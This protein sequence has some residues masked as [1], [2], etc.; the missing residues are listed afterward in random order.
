MS[1]AGVKRFSGF[2]MHE[3]ILAI[4]INTLITI[5]LTSPFLDIS[6]VVQS[7]VTQRVRG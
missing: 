4:C 6:I 3:T 2:S 7:A 5:F 1:T